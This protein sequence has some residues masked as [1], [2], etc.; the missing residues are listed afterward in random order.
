[1]DAQ[2][3]KRR[4]AMVMNASDIQSGMEVFGCDGEKIGSISDVYRTAAVGTETRASTQSW[5]TKTTGKAGDIVTEE[6]RMV[7][8]A[9]NYDATESEVGRYTSA[10]MPTGSDSTTVTAGTIIASGYFKV[11]HGGFLGIGAKELYFPFDAIETV[12]AGEN[13]TVKCARDDCDAFFATRPSFLDNDAE[14][15]PGP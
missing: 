1:L 15:K 8:T 13:I 12:V 9:E 4:L 7:K 3:S 6:V 2:I 11:D 5:G 14:N 10:Q